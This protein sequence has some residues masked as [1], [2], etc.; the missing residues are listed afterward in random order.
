M[1]LRQR[2]V[3]IIAD[4][5]L[6]AQLTYSMYVAQQVPDEIALVFMKTFFPMVICTLIA[7]RYFIRKFRSTDIDGASQ[8]RPPETR[9]SILPFG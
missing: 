5:L 8:L 4:M 2:I 7:G 9:P 6:L 3:V 1:N